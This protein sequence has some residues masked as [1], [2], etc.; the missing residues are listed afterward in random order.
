MTEM[1]RCMRLTKGI[2]GIFERNERAFIGRRSA[3]YDFSN[4]LLTS[5]YWVSYEMA[6][7]F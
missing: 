4:R 6:W 2:P 3:C 1:A 7:G 5:D